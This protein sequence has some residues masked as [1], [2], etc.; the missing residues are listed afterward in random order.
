MLSH[1]F[2]VLIKELTRIPSAPST[3]QDYEVD[4][5][6]YGL[7]ARSLGCNHEW[8]LCCISRGVEK[9][10]VIGWDEEPYHENR[11]N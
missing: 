10:R 3:G 7:Y 4:D 9:V 8:R 2:S 5:R 11:K 6:R 1:I